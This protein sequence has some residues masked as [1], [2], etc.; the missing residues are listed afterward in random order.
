MQKNLIITGAS[1]LVATELTCLLLKSTDYN[2]ILISTNIENI[3]DRYPDFQFRVSFYTLETFEMAL[4]NGEIECD[5]C[6][7]TAFARSGLGNLIVDSV[8]YEK[9]LIAVLVNSSLKTF[10][11]ISSQSVYGK[12][13]EPLWKE[14]THLDPDYLYAM[15]KYASEIVTEL[16]LKNTNIN[17][18]NIRLCSVCENARFIRIFVQNAL[19]GKTIHLTAP[20]QYCSFIDVRDVAEALLALIK[21]SYHI[22]L[23]SSYNL[24]ANL[25]N[26]IKEIAYLV[27]DIGEKQYSIKSISI[28]EEESD[29][30]TK[31]GMDASLFME[32]FGWKPR[33]NMQDMI[34]SLYEILLKNNIGTPISFKVL[35]HV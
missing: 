31:I 11:N 8:E 12:M 20:N 3:K 18:T 24:G 29:N 32:S 30:Y 15:G 2:L 23:L 4:K 13:S 7:H 28:C 35:Y 21:K 34:K 25:V 22:K 27:K 33:Y 1:G 26:S 19:E 10:I 14:T 9:K 16:M 17:W 5:I 6:I